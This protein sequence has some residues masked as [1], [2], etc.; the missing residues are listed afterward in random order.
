M[1]RQY[2]PVEATLVKVVLAVFLGII[3]SIAIIYMTSF[4]S[5][6][7]WGYVW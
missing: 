4:V 7:G 5:T 2:A 6:G 3:L 1:Y